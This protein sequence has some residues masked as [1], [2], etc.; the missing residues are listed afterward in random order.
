MTIIPGVWEIGFG[1]SMEQTASGRA[2]AVSDYALGHPIEDF[3]ETFKWYVMVYIGKGEI[4]RHLPNPET[5]KREP[6]QERRRAMEEILAV[7]S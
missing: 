2:G 1:V 3:A 7:F 6:S 5:G 4:K